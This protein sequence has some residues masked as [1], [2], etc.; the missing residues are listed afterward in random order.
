MHGAKEL[1]KS[2]REYFSNAENV[3]EGQLKLRKKYGHDCI[4]SFFYAPVEVEALGGEVI[5][6]DNGPPNSGNPIIKTGSHIESLHIPDIREKSC[7]QKILNATRQLKREVED[8]VPIIGVVMSPFSLPVMQMGFDKYFNLM[9]EEP[10][11]FE[12]LMRKNEEFC[13]AWANAQLDAGAT[14]ICY[15]D[16]V[17]SSSMIPKDMY[18]KTGYKIAKRTLQRINGPTATHLASGKSRP[19]I[20][21]IAETGTA[22]VGVSVNEDLVELKKL[23]KGR[24]TLLGNLNGIEMRNWTV[25]Q[26]KSKVDEAI[27]Q[28]GHGGGFILSDNHGEIPFQV[29]DSVLHS[30]AE[31]VKQYGQYPLISKQ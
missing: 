1:R 3:V 16:P 19:I 21:H 5:Y 4:Y 2:I 15:F 25:D 18:L 28:A 27:Q 23:C 9:Y 6:S 20:S 8:D 11:L 26:A 12:I 30:I 13:V 7:L 14:A 29:P 22:V 31:A 10:D 24:L 17:S